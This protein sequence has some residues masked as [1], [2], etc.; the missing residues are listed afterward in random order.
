MYFFNI[1]CPHRNDLYSNIIH[2]NLSTFFQTFFKFFSKDFL[3][4]FLIKNLIKIV[5]IF[6][7]NFYY[8]IMYFNVLIQHF[9]AELINILARLLLKVNYFF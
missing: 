2:S 6:I 5:L 7:Q 3:K 9:V 1:N 4:T 8:I